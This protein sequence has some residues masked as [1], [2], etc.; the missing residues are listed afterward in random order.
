MAD[1]QE[2]QISSTKWRR[3]F[4][5]AVRNPSAPATPTI[6]FF[7]EDV[8]TV[9]DALIR[10]SE[11]SCG[12]SYNP[13]AVVDVYDPVTLQPTGQ[14]F[15]HEQLYGMLFSAYLHTALARDETEA[16]AQQPTP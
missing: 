2:S 4:Q 16:A 10:L 11:T 15:T 9:G 12:V 1:Y 13:S 6:Q 5:L 14:T 8:A 7:E 3:C